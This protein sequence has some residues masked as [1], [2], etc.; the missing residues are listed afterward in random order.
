MR[1]LLLTLAILCGSAVSMAAPKP[2]SLHPLAQ[3]TPDE[4]KKAVA[5]MQR[6]SRWPAAAR[7]MTIGLREQPKD[8]LVGRNANDGPREIM[9]VLMDVRKHTTYEMSVDARTW[10]VSE[11]LMRTLVQPMLV[12]EDFAL[13]DSIVRAHPRWKNAM[14]RRGI[15]TNDAVTD[16]WACGTPTSAFKQRLV[17]TVTYIT[18]NGVNEYDRP[19][20]GVSCLVDLS[21]K[22]VM[23][24]FDKPAVPVPD[25]SP[26]LAE[27]RKQGS[28][29]PLVPF[30]LKHA[31]QPFTL[32]GNKVSWQNWSFRAVMHPREGLVIYDVRYRDGARD[33]RIA[34]RLGLSEM[35]VPYGDSS[36]LWSWRNAFDAGEYGVGQTSFPMV[37]GADVPAEAVMLPMAMVNG[38]G[39]V[40]SVPDVLGIYERDGGLA[41]RHTDPA[42]KATVAR[43]ARDLVVVHT[44]TVGNYDYAVAWVFQ[45]DG[46]IKVEISLSGIMLAK[47]V[48]DTIADPVRYP[49][50]EHGALV[51][52]HTLAPMHQHFFCFRLD[53]DVD[54]TKN[55]VQEVDVRSPDGG[56]N[57]FGNAMIMD[58]FE[59]RYE[60]EARRM[61]DPKRARTWVVSNVDS[62]NALRSPTAYAIVPGSSTVPFLRSSH[63]V[64][65]RAGFIDHHLWVT[66]YN[67]NELYAAGPY[68]NQSKADDGLPAFVADNEPLHGRDLVVWHTIGLTHI[69]RPE[70]WNIMPTHRMGFTIMPMGFFNAAPNLDLP[71]PDWKLPKGR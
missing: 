17:R 7:I 49:G 34:W 27:R 22:R 23:E 32:D 51:A 14:A 15:D 43:R 13:T 30:T 3:P 38:G 11:F 4:L 5:A 9:A 45:L 1:T 50:Q 12:D 24:I 10:T 62:V 26:T 44:A 65:N 59:F 41:W 46:S 29:P 40:R 35:L 67:D 36:Q 61:A 48:H 70:D 37:R 63:W 60:Q 6:D 52:R 54:G 69:T 2:K 16:A 25:P 55:M 20:E 19:V 57:P 68:P 39:T 33:R 66:R 71:G 28:R 18:R 47:G 56:E 58:A 42:T 21:S 53:L 31:R 64:R 8:S